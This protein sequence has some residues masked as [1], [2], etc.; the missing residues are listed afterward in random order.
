MDKTFRSLDVGTLSNLISSARER[1]VFIS[2]GLHAEVFKSLAM[3]ISSVP[4]NKIHIVLDVDAEVCRLGYGAIEGLEAIQKFAMH[5]GVTI[6]HHPGIRIGLVVADNTTVIYAPT[7]LLIEAGSTSPDDKPNAIWLNQAVPIEIAN[8]CAIG[9]AGFAALEVGKDPISP[10]SV[11]LVKEDLRM[12]PPKKFDLARIELVFN[13]KLHFVELEIKDYRLQ[14]QAVK[15]DADLFGIKDQ[16]V[17][18]RLSSKYQ[19]FS[20]EKDLTVAIP[21]LDDQ[22]NPDKDG[23]TEDFNPSCID[24]ERKAISDYFFISAGRLGMLILR[25]NKAD[26]ENRLFVL[27]KKIDSYKAAIYETIVRRKDGIAESIYRAIKDQLAANPP[28]KMRKTCFSWP[29]VEAD[30]RLYAM[31]EIECALS[32]VKIDFNPSIFHTYKDV[33]YSTFQD[34]EFKKVIE[35]NFGE[36]AF[37]EIYKEYNAAAEQS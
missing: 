9:E 13:S 23:V 28:P 27:Q 5:H 8:A 26:F 3:A 33:T 17:A 22:G 31:A 35:N 29:P 1:L 19:I 25:C 14:S 4:T 37:G 11:N 7:P 16:D 34:K 36:A 6:N 10:E 24:K 21:L 32:K 20:N 12:N 30:I 18:K 2:P 15:L